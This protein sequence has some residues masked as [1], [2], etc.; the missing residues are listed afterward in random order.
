MSEANLN[1][2]TI[3]SDRALAGSPAQ[4]GA[5]GRTDLVPRREAQGAGHG[6]PQPGPEAREQL[7]LHDGRGG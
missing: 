6:H 4:S 5:R 3:V 2:E 1:P 7:L